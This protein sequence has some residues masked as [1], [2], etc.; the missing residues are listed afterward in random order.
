MS[1]KN[2]SRVRP[3]PFEQSSERLPWLGS[4]SPLSHREI[5]EECFPIRAATST[6]ERPRTFR[7]PAIRSAMLSNSP[8][9]TVPILAGFAKLR[10]GYFDNACKS[11]TAKLSAVIEQTDSYARWCRE[12]LAALERHGASSE[13]ARARRVDPSWVTRLKKQL[14][15]RMPL[16]FAV[17]TQISD[18]LKLRPP[19]YEPIDASERRVLAALRAV[20]V[21]GVEPDRVEELVIAFEEMCGELADARMRRDKAAAEEERLWSSVRRKSPD[22][23]PGSSR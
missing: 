3:S 9:V 17:V 16:D 7:H 15:Q 21:A 1:P 20:V 5:E 12:V 4:T 22:S 2:C 13:L 19:V 8:R 6:C 10:Q 18:H 11:N 23:D 14:E